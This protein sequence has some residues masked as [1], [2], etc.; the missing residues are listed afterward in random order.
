MPTHAQLPGNPAAQCEVFEFEREALS[1]LPALMAA[2][3]RLTRQNSE[4]EDLV[5]DTYVKA[6][7]ARKQ[8][9]P[10]T[11]LRAWLLKILRNTFINRYHRASLERSVLGAAVPDPVADG[12]LSS[13]S[14]LAIRDPEAATLRPELEREIASAIDSLPTEFREVVVLADVEEFSYREIAQTLGCPLGT[15]MSRLHRAR[16]LL[17][18]KLI[19][20]A[21]E[22]GL[23]PEVEQRPGSPEGPIDLLEYRRNSP[24]KVAVASGGNNPK[25]GT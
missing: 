7:R 24:N 2:A 3:R 13:A 4:A 1:H 14:M 19:Q 20:H 25:G 17:K 10:G 8:Y 22:T 9:Q 15:V 11:H 16:K 18:S 6:I 12:W 23:V 5:Q 21:R